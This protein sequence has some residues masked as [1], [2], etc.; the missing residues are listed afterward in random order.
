MAEDSSCVPMNAILIGGT[1][2][3]GGCLLGALLKSKVRVSRLI[4]HVRDA[5]SRPPRTNEGVRIK[6]KNVGDVD[7]FWHYKMLEIHK[8]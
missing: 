3:T 5:L 4:T 8:K 7:A 6:P 1:G 2:A